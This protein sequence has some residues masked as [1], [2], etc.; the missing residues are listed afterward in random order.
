MKFKDYLDKQEIRPYVFAKKHDLN[1]VMVWRAYKGNQ[2]TPKNAALISDKCKGKVSRIE[3]L[4][5]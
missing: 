2:I 3:L 1:H 5:I 4:Y